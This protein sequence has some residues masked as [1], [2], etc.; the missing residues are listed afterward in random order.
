MAGRHPTTSIAAKSEHHGGAN[1]VKSES[2]TGKP[3]TGA[4][5]GSASEKGSVN[6]SAGIK[7]V[8]PQL[9]PTAGQSRGPL[10]HHII[11]TENNRGAPPTSGLVP[12]VPPPPYY[13]Q[14]PPYPGYGAPGPQMMSS[15]Q[16]KGPTAGTPMAPPSMAGSRDVSSLFDGKLFWTGW[17]VS[18]LL[19]SKSGYRQLPPY[20]LEC[21]PS[22]ILILLI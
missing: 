7:G 4:P 9:P 10:P 21:L 11:K 22:N 12:G 3:V 2:A 19:T 15:S 16:L 6:S 14:M 20:L 8:P 13:G 1:S 5:N 18:P 17:C